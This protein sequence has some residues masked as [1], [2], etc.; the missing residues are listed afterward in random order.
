MCR[1]AAIMMSILSTVASEYDSDPV[2]KLREELGTSVQKKPGT[3][4]RAIKQ[5][6]T[7]YVHVPA[8]L[9]CCLS[10]VTPP[11]SQYLVLL[12]RIWWFALQK[13]ATYVVR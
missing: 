9:I 13:N 3:Q 1:L 11:F 4:L 5:P 2:D 8:L 6:A 10:L 7:P 12:R